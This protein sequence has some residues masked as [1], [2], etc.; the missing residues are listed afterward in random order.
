MRQQSRE[1]EGV[2]EVAGVMGVIQGRDPRRGTT[3]EG[4]SRGRRM[5]YTM[6]EKLSES[7]PCEVAITL[8]SS[9]AF[10]AL[11][12]EPEIRHDLVQLICSA[13]SRAFQSRDRSILQHLAGV[14]KDSGFLRTI[15]PQYIG[16]MSSVSDPARR[17]QYPHH[18]DNIIA[19]LSKVLNTYPF[20]SVQAVSV[21]VVLF[22]D[23]LLRLKTLG[24]DIGCQTEEKLERIQA[25]VNDLQERC[26]EGI[27]RSDR[28]HIPLLSDQ[29]DNQ[30]ERPYL[31]PNITTRQHA[32]VETYLDTHFRLLR[33][34][35]VRPLR[36]GIQKLIWSG[37]DMRMNAE[38]LK[39]QRFDDISVYF[40]A[41]LGMPMYIVE[42]SP[43]VEPPR[44]LREN[45]M[46]NLE[47]VADR[48]SKSQIKPFHSLRPADWPDKS[49]LNLDESQMEAFQLALTQELAIIQG[50]PGTGKTYVGLKIAQ[51]LLTNQEL[52]SAG[53]SQHQLLSFPHT[54]LPV[55]LPQWKVKAV[56][57]KPL[58]VNLVRFRHDLDERITLCDCIVLHS[59]HV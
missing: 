35:F 12:D 37:L 42:C 50:P 54:L 4:G 26:R 39:R 15:L 19:V 6:L 11:L 18:L 25:L 17:E 43:D 20:S 28:D 29:H 5:T 2:G 33:E 13:L 30:E 10:Q 44:Y 36:E 27:L 51:A 57:D 32:N 21:L 38:E 16:G 24:V 31:R 48:G 56:F 55:N 46:Y 3:S 23:S 14:V 1:E 41:K 9:P 47:H 58:C 45:D 34:D 59:V 52:W 22:R 53:H 7:Q 40:D 49:H 8:S